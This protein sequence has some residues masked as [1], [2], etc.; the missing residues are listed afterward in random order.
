MNG[1][2]SYTYDAVGNRTQKVSTL[3]GYP[4]GLSNY[5]VNDELTTDAYDADGNTVGSGTNTGTNGYVYDFENHLIQQAGISIVYDGDGNRVSKSTANATTQ[6]LVDDLN[7]TGYAQVM[8]EVQSSA[9]V[10]TYTWGLE[11]ISELFPVGSPLST[12]HSPLYYIFDGHGSVRALTDQSGAV[13]DTYD[14]DA[15]GNLIHSTGTTPNNYLFAGE[16]FD[17]DLGLYFNRARYLN[18]STGRFFTADSLE[19]HAQLPLSLNA[20]LY[21]SGDATNNLDPTG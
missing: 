2:S 20:Y 13:T 21:A 5:N 11:L 16:Q 9:V 6:Y 7:P 4:G 8:D 1:A 12:N 14:Y 3:P 18:T 19:G 15:F 10:R 17:P